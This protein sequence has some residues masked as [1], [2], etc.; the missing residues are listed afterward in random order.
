MV[1]FPSAVRIVAASPCARHQKVTELLL[2]N[3]T[4]T[5]CAVMEQNPISS[6]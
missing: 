4:D 2:L 6:L 3:S 1:I 5:I